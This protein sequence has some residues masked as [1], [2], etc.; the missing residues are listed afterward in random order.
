[1]INT[2]VD[3]DLISRGWKLEIYG[4]PDDELYLKRIKRITR[5]LPEIKILDPVF[6]YEKAKIINRSWANILI[7]KS[8]VLS[9]SILESGVYGLPSVVTNNIET[10][11]H[12]SFS[13]KVND[14]PV[15]I[16]E[17]LKSIGDWSKNKRQ[18]IGQKTS[19]FFNN[20]KKKSDELFIKNLKLSY[21][22]VFYQ[23]IYLRGRTYENFYIASLV[24]SLNVFMP[25]IILLLS[26]FFFNSKLAAEI[27][28]TNIVFITLTQM[29]SGN[30][31]LIAIKKQSISF[32]QEHLFFRVSIGA[33]ILLFYQ[34][35]S[36]KY[37]FLDDNYTNLIMSLFIVLLWCSELVLTIFEIKR[38]IG[39][40]LI[41]L[42]VYIL[43][44]I[45]L[46]ISFFTSDI[47]LMRYCILFS[48]LSLIV[49]CYKGI[50]YQKAKIINYKLF[51]SFFKDILKYFS[52]L[53]LTLS[54]FCWRFY[55]YFTYPKEISGT[56]FIAF[57]ICSFPG[58][59]FNNVLGPNFFYN[60]IKI[61]PKIK[62]FFAIIFGVLLIYNVIDFQIYNNFNSQEKELFYHVLKISSLGS[63]LM[64][65]AMYTRQDLV[66]RKK[67]KLENLFYKD[68][69]YGLI[70]ILIL[71]LLDIIGQINFVSFSYLIGAIFAILIFKINYSKLSNQQLK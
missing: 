25:N 5:E 2:F 20:Y 59:F 7:S 35:L 66:F 4:I 56:I 70:L 41:I 10:L 54:S 43:V 33:L 32:L 58:T 48:C 31:R 19:K 60:R 13:Q 65:Y 45:I 61:N 52:S 64:F 57:A 23:K 71:P 29:L 38:K 36:G 69:S 28:L 46:L 30:I 47:A 67:L 9:F 15:Q 49:F 34:F 40:L 27:G 68:I 39:K 1:M 18:I 55:L 26:F 21:E 51:K 8:E 17:K 53:S 11:K 44:L 42:S 12:D 24:H 3:S 50:F 63:F 22:Q 16:S 37:E 62:Y 14:E 6:G